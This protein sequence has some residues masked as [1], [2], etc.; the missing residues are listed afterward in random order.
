MKTVQKLKLIEFIDG[1]FF[2]TIV[3][4]LFAIS[5][6]VSLSNA[7]IAQSIF[8]GTVFLSEIPT[9][10]IADKFG[11]KTSMALGYFLNVLGLL[12]IV[13]SPTTFGLYAMNIIRAIGTA[14]VSGA[15]EALLFEAS[16]EEGLNYKK[17]SSIVTS[18]GIAGLF[19]A[20]LITAVIYGEFN[21]ASYVPL[22][23][24]T[25]ALQLFITVFALTLKD[26]S[27]ESKHE[28][29]VQEEVK[30]FTSLTKT[31]HLMKNNKTIFALTMI[32]LLTICNEYFLYGTYGPHFEASSVNNFWVGAAFSA[33]LFINFVLQRYVYLIEN[34]L[35]FEK[36][37]ALI[38]SLSIIGYFGLALA[39]QSP[40]IVIL[41]IS[42]IGVFNLERPIVSDYANQ[43][44]Q[45]NIRATVLSGMSLASRFAKMI[46]TFL[47]GLIIAGG[48]LKLGYFVQAA[49]MIVGLAISYWL[50]VRCGC[51]RKFKH[52][53]D[54]P[55][56]VNSEG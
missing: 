28:S 6:G 40:L 7:V 22:I 30:M 16:Q 26:S 19:A 20:G 9:G 51:V 18:N 31:F 50:L 49:F 38:K 48:S 37:F 52:P 12:V 24:A 14:M 47:L 17:Q 46:L 2:A 44:M 43:E 42:T 34:Y 10:F 56:T 53:H 32:G 3:T 15:N 33:G 27:K 11:R 41:V 4:N 13:F 36:A 54:T 39:T 55:V 45:S 8:A 23:L 5:Q 35:T 29:V 1:M 25:A 21:S